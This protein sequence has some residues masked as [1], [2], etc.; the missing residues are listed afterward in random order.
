MKSTNKH[1]QINSS[2]TAQ[3]A[4]YP[5]WHNVVAGAAAGAGARLLTAPLDL[6]KIRRQLLAPSSPS[7]CKN[8]AG[9]IFASLSNIAKAEGGV[10][11]LFRGNVAAT[12][13]W[14][15]YAAVQF[16]LYAR[17]SEFLTHF[18]NIPTP[19]L[20]GEH[21]KGPSAVMQNLM[22][23]LG[24]SPAAVAFAS[25]ATAGVCATL[26][27]YPF[28]ICRTTFAAQ[29]LSGAPPETMSNRFSS[30]A[31]AAAS[32]VRSGMK[33][34]ETI[35]E[36]ARAMYRQSGVRGFFAGSHPAVVQ[37]IPYMGINFALYD[38][39]VRFMDR[40]SVGNAGLAG[41]VAGG[42]SKLLVYPLD[43]VKK[44]LQVQVSIGGGA[45]RY[46]GMMDCF[47]TIVREEGVPVLYRGLGT[48]ML[49]SCAGSG[50]SFAFFTLTKNTLESIHDR[51]YL[52]GD[53]TSVRFLGE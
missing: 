49:K 48:Q 44:R 8:S 31:S 50:F 32:L 18:G 14:I 5:R 35:P 1:S 47:M 33:P 2:K 26:A 6:L 4:E 43:T 52:K 11:S 3:S 53:S 27:T 7:A 23:D 21:P 9:S 17:T 12:Y 38:Y 15:G 30:S 39:F 29:G 28:D 10:R 42:S 37:I 46:K 20:G 24:S 41:M 34:P 16:S 40:R 22:R 19:L 13:L 36:F 45:L 25:G 51:R